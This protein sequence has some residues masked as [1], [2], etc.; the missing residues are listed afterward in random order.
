MTWR[1]RWAMGPDAAD[2]ADSLRPGK[3][4]GNS[5]DAGETVCEERLERP[6]TVRYRCTRGDEGDVGESLLQRRQTRVALPSGSDV[7]LAPSAEPADSPIVG[8]EPRA[9]RPPQRNVEP[10]RSRDDPMPS[11]GADGQRRPQ[12]H[13]GAVDR[14]LDSL[15][16][17]VRDQD[18]TDMGAFVHLHARLA[19]TIEEQRVEPGAGEPNGGTPRLGDPEIGKKTM[20][21]WRMDEHGLHAVRAQSLQVARE[22]QLGE[23]PRPCRVDVFGAGFVARETR[24]VEEQDAVTPL[25]E[26]PRRDTSGGAAPDDDSVGIELRHVRR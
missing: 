2:A 8:H 13:A 9:P 12:D 23:Q 19:G 7:H 11:V 26:E 24:L 22:S 25:G 18:V 16:R 6:R 14:T 3:P 21:A 4:G 10:E 15:H 20:P 1:A 5:R 17:A